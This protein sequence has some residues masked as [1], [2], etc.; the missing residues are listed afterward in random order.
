MIRLLYNF[1]KSCILPKILIICFY[2]QNQISSQYGPMKSL[3]LTNPQSLM[4]L[5]L[6]EQLR[7]P[8]PGANHGIGILPPT[9]VPSLSNTSSSVS[10]IPK[11]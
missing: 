4:F 1:N 7:L 11:I 2:L 5:P 3:N 8:L 10:E 6:L 9:P